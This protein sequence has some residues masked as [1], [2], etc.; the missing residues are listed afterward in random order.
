M[1]PTIQAVKGTREFYPENMENRQW[2]YG[3]IR[4]VS[5]LFGYQEWDGPF[6]EKIDLYAA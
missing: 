6:L 2:L 3:Q 1:K 5:E 4:K